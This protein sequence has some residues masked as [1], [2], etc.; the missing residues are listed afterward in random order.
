MKVFVIAH[1]AGNVWTY[2]RLFSKIKGHEFIPVEL[3]GN[4]TRF[5][6][7][8]PDTFEEYLDIAYQIIVEQIGFDEPIALFGHSFGGYFMYD[9]S[10]RLSKNV[11]QVFISCSSPF[12]LYKLPDENIDYSTL[13]DFPVKPDKKIADI[14]NP[15]IRHK[16]VLIDKYKDRF[17]SNDNI[18]K[19][20]ETY[21]TFICAEKDVMTGELDEWKKYF[22]EKKTELIRFEG[23]HFYWMES[24]ENQNKLCELIEERLRKYES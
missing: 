9:L 11:K 2:V 20:P 17:L 13:Y 4:V 15:I 19:S 10:K 21:A 6:D 14:F 23:K 22:D 3:P 5:K 12:H 8:L 16:I 24:M 7:K 1:S 18:I